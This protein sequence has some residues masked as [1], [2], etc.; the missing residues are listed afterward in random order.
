MVQCSFRQVSGRYLTNLHQIK[1]VFTFGNYC[2]LQGVLTQPLH[3]V[4]LKPYPGTVMHSYMAAPLPGLFPCYHMADTDK[5]IREV[6]E[7][8]K[9]CS[10]RDQHCC[11]SH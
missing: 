8:R 3:T 9:Q 1:D 4:I 10:G 2:K 7:N 5:M 11:E 6:R